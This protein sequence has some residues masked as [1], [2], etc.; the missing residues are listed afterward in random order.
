L[1]IHGSLLPRWRG[2]APIQRAIATGDAETGITI[3]QMAAG[4]DTGDMM[5]KTYC[6]ITAEDTSATCMTNWRFKV[7]K[8][9]VPYSNLNKAC[10]I[11]SK[12]VKY[13]MKHSRSMHIN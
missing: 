13:K 4:L 8:R 6:P 7:Q 11:L 10:R 12:N 1:N 9:F 2:A 3:M 5:Y